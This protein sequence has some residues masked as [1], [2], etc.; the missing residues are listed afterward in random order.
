MVRLYELAFSSFNHFLIV[1]V[2]PRKI[3]HAI[4]ARTLEKLHAIAENESFCTLGDYDSK[5][6]YQQVL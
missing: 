6:S 3:L 5:A 2:T 4:S 1:P